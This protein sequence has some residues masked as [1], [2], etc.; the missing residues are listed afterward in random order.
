M[1]PDIELVTPSQTSP[2]HFNVD[3]FNTVVKPLLKPSILACDDDPVFLQTLQRTARKNGLD[4]VAVEDARHIH[5]F[6][7]RHFDLAIVDFDLGGLSGIDV[8]HYLVKEFGFL[9]VLLVSY[10]RRCPSSG[11]PWP[12]AIKKFVT[13]DGGAQDVLREA[14]LLWDRKN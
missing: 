5:Q 9:P 6:A 12:K 7:F 2:Y 1:T 13:K 10:T 11:E 14:M 3:G 8:T 4:L